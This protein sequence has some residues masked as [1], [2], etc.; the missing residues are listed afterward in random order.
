MSGAQ[1]LLAELKRQSAQ[2]IPY[3]AIDAAVAAR[4]RAAAREKAQQHTAVI[5]GVRCWGSKRAIETLLEL[6]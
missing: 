1:E 6:P 5:A 2:P 4:T 3:D